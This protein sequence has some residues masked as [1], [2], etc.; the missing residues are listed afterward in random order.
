[1]NKLFL[2]NSLVRFIDWQPAEE[3]DILVQPP[4]N[5]YFYMNTRIHGITADHTEDSPTFAEVWQQIAPSI[6]DHN[7]VAH[8]G[9]GFDFNC[10]KQ[11]LALYGIVEPNYTNHCTLKLYG[12]ALDVLC[13]KHKIPLNH[14]DALSDARA[15]GELFRRK[16]LP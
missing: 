3:L 11:T 9:F 10:L 6:I 14:H 2:D 4:G 5:E 13:R 7:V 15:C 12:E 1:M 16:Y 8:N